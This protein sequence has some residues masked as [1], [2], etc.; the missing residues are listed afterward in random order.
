MREVVSVRDVLLQTGLSR[1]T[2]HRLRM[3]GR[4]PNAVRLSERRIGFF[5]ADVSNWL[6]GHRSI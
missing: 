5:A 3:S 2:L 4:F 1:T 6:E